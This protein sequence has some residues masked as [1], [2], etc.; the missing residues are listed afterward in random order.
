V[1]HSCKQC[2]ATVEDGV[3]FCPNCGTPQ[4][5]VAIAR[6]ELE[7]QPAPGTSGSDSDTDNDQSAMEAIPAQR[8]TSAFS[9]AEASQSAKYERRVVIFSALAAGFAA[10]IGSLVPFVPFITLC[11]VAAGGIAITLY[12]RRM[13]YVS[14]PARR[15]FRI[16]ALAGFFGFLLNAVTS[17]L[18]MFSA[19]EPRGSARRHAG[20]AQRS[21]VGQFRSVGAADGEAPRGHGLHPQR[22]G[23]RVCFFAVPFWL[24]LCFAERRWGCNR[25]GLV[26]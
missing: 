13:P 10:G 25:R 7:T 24:A 3:P 12:K 14:V 22:T 17:V 19:G 6:E 21:P 1:E 20:A 5:R 11:M 4:I 2:G 9:Q 8:A 15:G 18:G 26:R 16:G 23:R